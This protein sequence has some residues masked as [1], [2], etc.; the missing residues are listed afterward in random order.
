MGASGLE[1][2]CATEATGSAVEKASGDGA[3]VATGVGCTGQ[4][5][6]QEMLGR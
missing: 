4:A 1:S 2:G 6:W 5:R 3:D